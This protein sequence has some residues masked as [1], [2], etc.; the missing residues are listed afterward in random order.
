MKLPRP[1]CLVGLLFRSACSRLDSGASIPENEAFNIRDSVD[2]N[3]TSQE[4]E[5]HEAAVDESA[6][7]VN[8]IVGVKN[9]FGVAS[10]SKRAREFHTTKL[11]KIDAVSA[12][13]KKSEIAALK[14][15]PDIDFVEM[16]SMYY[17][18]GEAVLYGTEMIQ[19]FSPQI[20]KI[21]DSVIGSCSDPSSFKIGI[22]DSGVAV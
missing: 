20:P 12:K 15:D 19:A 16:D 18:D 9:G 1:F 11:K 14:Q 17:P 21:S 4:Q 5:H 2:R 6:E 10:V 8:V 22:V 13:M 7:E 3:R